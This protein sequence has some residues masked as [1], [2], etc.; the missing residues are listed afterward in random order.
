MYV[1]R[2][3]LPQMGPAES[4]ACMYVCMYVDRKRSD[5]QCMRVWVYVYVGVC[6]CMLKGRR[7][8]KPLYMCVCVFAYMV[9]GK[10]AV[11]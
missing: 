11:E 7:L 10:K 1:D 3:A 5:I 9:A 4:C 6:V 8:D 2:K